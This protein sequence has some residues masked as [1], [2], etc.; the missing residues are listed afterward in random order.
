MSSS[1]VK[2]QPAFVGIKSASLCVALGVSAFVM[3]SSAQ[4]PGA[5]WLSWI[6]LLPLF[7]AIKTLVPS[8][9]F[10]SG[11]F[12]GLCLYIFSS[13]GST[14]IIT[15]SWLN[16]V[17]VTLIPGAYALGGSVV[18]RRAGFSPLLLGLGWLGVEIA[19]S[20]LS[21]N[22][23]LLA[24]M[25]IGGALALRAVGLIA[26]WFVVAFLIAYVNAS[27][28]EMLTEVCVSRVPLRTAGLAGRLDNRVLPVQAEVRAN[29]Q[30]SPA[31]PRGPPV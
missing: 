11:A 18:T 23:G 1:P 16:L 13:V 24:S 10:L 5:R 9:A 8:R 26:G 3:A 30:F 27:L 29:A 2:S 7:V 22:Y 12:W 14:P 25:Q 20:P 17:L 21:P 19:M 28:L 15:Q 31:K 6:A 4:L